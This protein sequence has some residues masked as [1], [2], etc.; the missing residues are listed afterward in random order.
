[1]MRLTTLCFVVFCFSLVCTIPSQKTT[2]VAHP[3]PVTATET[4]SNKL[5]QAANTAGGDPPK[6]ASNSADADKIID[7]DKKTSTTDSKDTNPKALGGGSG[8]P[9]GSKVANDTKLNETADG[10]VTKKGESVEKQLTKPNKN[11]A[12]A[13][14]N[15]N[16]GNDST[17]GS[18]T[19]IKQK[20]TEGKQVKPTVAKPAKNEEGTQ[21]KPSTDDQNTDE[22][23]NEDDQTEPE[24]PTEDNQEGDPDEDDDVDLSEDQGTADHKTENLG[25][26]KKQKEVGQFEENAE[27]SHFFAYLVCA[28]ILVAV[29]YI[30]NHNKRKIIAFVVEGRRSRG[31][32]R[33]KTADYQKLDQH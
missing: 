28:I 27:S 5:G 15:N 2:T 18:T 22:Y 33:P 23:G 30:A 6:P 11:I 17:D 32:R 26:N 8:D 29:L 24:T 14:K 13:D 19:D 1:M 12:A 9:P 3:Q 25:S 4:K 31:T 10:A 7:E 20:T 16:P 21:K